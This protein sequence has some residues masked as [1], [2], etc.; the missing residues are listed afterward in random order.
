MEF[1]EM[2]GAT[3]GAVTVAYPDGTRELYTF[4]TESKAK[5]FVKRTRRKARETLNLPRRTK[6]SEPVSR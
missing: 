5:D 6:V 1:R 2:I 4:D 3:G